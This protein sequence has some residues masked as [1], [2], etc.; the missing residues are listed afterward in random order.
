MKKKNRILL[1]M[2]MAFCMMLCLLPVHAAAEDARPVVKI[3]VSG[4]ITKTDDYEITSSNIKLLQ[5][6]K[7]Y[8]LTGTTTK[9]INYWGSNDLNAIRTF[10]LRLNNVTTGNITGT[11]SDGA[12]VVVDVP[13]GTVNNIGSMYSVDLN[14]TGSGTINAT[15]LGVTQS[16]RVPNKLYIKDTTIVTHVARNSDGWEG[17]CVLAG[18]ANVTYIGNGKYAPLKL[19]QKIGNTHSLTIQDNAKLY[20]LQDDSKPVPDSS[21][22]GMEI[23][24]NATLTLK[25]NGYLEA[26][27]M[28]STGE[29]AGYGLVTYSDIKVQDNATIKAI[30]Y[31]VGLCAEGNL[32]VTGGSIT[33]ESSSS[34]GIYASGTIDISNADIDAKG[35]YP[36]I[37]GG[38]SVSISD[39]TVKAEATG[40]CAIFSRGSVTLKDSLVKATA[41]DDDRGINANSGVKVSGCW[42]QTSGTETLADDPDTIAD[43]VLFNKNKGKTIGNA[44][45][46]ADE[47]IEKD[48]TLDIGEGTS[49]TVP[50]GKTLT[51]NGTINLKGTLNRDGTIICNSHIGGTATCT[52][53]AKCDICLEPYGELAP[54]NHSDLKHVDAKAAT[55]TSEGNIE[56]WYCSGCGKYFSDA[57]AENEIT[58]ADTITAKLKDDQKNDNNNDPAGETKSTKTGD[59]TNLAMWLALLALSGS[60]AAGITIVSRKKRHSGR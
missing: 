32:T 3:D 52:E 26:H 36:A 17:E 58:E 39:S 54:D 14:I 9:T 21:V 6:D 23:F 30:G 34:N 29:Y 27:G 11:N 60:S 22:S 31:D 46:L 43:S 49:L 10:Y 20:C 7:I 53:K 2:C 12:K 56:Y 40:N 51:N 18:S 5:P 24:E 35:Y 55:K 50:E 57:N 1:A 42:I 13:A 37:F 8:E 15:S 4:E 16:T 59:D 38:K 44:A 41:P 33:A 45:L 47:T 25:D 19:G 48:M 28:D